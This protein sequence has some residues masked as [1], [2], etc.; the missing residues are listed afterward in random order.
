MPQV[1]PA[2]AIPREG[3]PDETRGFPRLGLLGATCSRIWGSRRTGSRGRPGPG[4]SRRQPH[5]T[6]V[7][8]RSERRM[9]VSCAVPHGFLEPANIGFERR[10][11]RPAGLLHRGRSTVRSPTEQADA[12]RIRS[13]PA[14]LGARGHAPAEPASRRRPWSCGARSLPP[15]LARSRSRRPIARA[16]FLPRRCVGAPTDYAPRVVPPKPA[17]HPDGP[18]HPGDVRSGFRIGGEDHSE[19]AMMA[20]SGAAQ[21][22]LI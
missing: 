1:S 8:R 11:T 9:V 2:R 16:G 7:H 18:P 21:V 19:Q 17:E 10:W 4:G 14:V 3:R 5:G 6:H 22:N 20:G 13:L 12:D 15:H